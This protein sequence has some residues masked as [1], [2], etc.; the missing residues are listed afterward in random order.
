MKSWR[1]G[2]SRYARHSLLVSGLAF[3]VSLVGCYPDS[4][5]NTGESTLVVTEQE[6]A[7]YQANR[8]YAINQTV[9][10][11]R[12]R[13]ANPNRCARCGAPLYE[14]GLSA[15]YWDDR[16]VDP[17]VMFVPAFVGLSHRC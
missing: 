7:D 2:M 16:A 5:S 14:R 6:D 11:V 3:G 13:C 8:T 1:E 15:W 4:I 12:C 10:D 9:V 17:G